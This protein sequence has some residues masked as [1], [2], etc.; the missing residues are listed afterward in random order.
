MQ[1]CHQVA[2][3]LNY[4]L[5]GECGDDVLRSLYVENVIPAP[6]SSRLLVTVSLLDKDDTTPTEVILMKLGMVQSKLRAEVARSISRRKTPELIFNIVR[7]DDV[8]WNSPEAP[9]TEFHDDA[10]EEE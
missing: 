8:P 5:S 1:L 6:D 3:T 2:H 10:D 7:P 4:V 9:A